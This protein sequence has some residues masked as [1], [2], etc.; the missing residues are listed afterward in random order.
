[1]IIT[2]RLHPAEVYT[3]NGVAGMGAAIDPNDITLFADGDETADYDDDYDDIG[4]DE[5][6]QTWLRSLHR[7]RQDIQHESQRQRV[8]AQRQFDHSSDSDSDSDDSLLTTLGLNN[9][10][11][12][13]FGSL[14]RRRREE[15]QQQQQPERPRQRPR[16][17]S[18]AR[19]NDAP[20]NNNAPAAV[21]ANQ[22]ALA[23]AGASALAANQP[24]PLVVGNQS[25]AAGASAAP[26]NRRVTA[27]ANGRNS[28]GDFVL[29]GNHH[30]RPNDMRTVEHKDGFVS[31]MQLAANHPDGYSGTIGR[32][33]RGRWFSQ[34]TERFFAEGGPLGRFSPV[35]HET[36]KRVFGLALQAG[37]TLGNQSH[38]SAP[39]GRREDLPTWVRLVMEFK[40]SV[41]SHQ[42]ATRQQ[43]AAREHSASIARS[44]SGAQAPLGP[45]PPGIRELRHERSTNSG[46]RSMR[47]QTIGGVVTERVRVP[48]Q[49]GAQGL[50]EGRDDVFTAH[51]APTNGS[52]SSANQNRSRQRNVNFGPTSL[53]DR[54][55]ITGRFVAGGQM[56]Q[57]I[58]N[59]TST[60][61]SSTNGILHQLNQPAPPQRH[62]GAIAMDIVSINEQMDRADPANQEPFRLLLQG[63]LAEAQHFFQYH[64][65][66]SNILAGQNGDNT[67]NG[68]GS[69]NENGATNNNNNINNINNMNNNGG[70]E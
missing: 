13:P 40:D 6:S 59:L 54:N 21:S 32:G 37:T 12:I 50:V 20:N 16:I 65:Y 30:E 67:V 47:S 42:N 2:R 70:G 61:V 49:D 4:L 69:S 48:V 24:D 17:A 60:L 58:E 1:M 64:Q 38:S 19:A 45:A 31:L 7:R 56:I 34:N 18:Q 41:S 62:A 55:N 11:S 33:S 44:V 23:V 3:L 28:L 63:L 10:R 15:Q 8:A 39:G 22:P 29:P 51:P 35:G 26:A 43:E 27:R 53:Y 9:N 66:S 14:S 46:D 5:Q 57:Q 25:V 52:G 68:S 36:L